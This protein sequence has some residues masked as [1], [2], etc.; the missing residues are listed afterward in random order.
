MPTLRSFNLFYLL[1]IVF[2]GLPLIRKYSLAL[3]CV[4]HHVKAK[5]R[6]T[7]LMDPLK[8]YQRNDGEGVT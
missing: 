3:L 5:L 4:L 6:P 1:G 2:C 7:I 8:P